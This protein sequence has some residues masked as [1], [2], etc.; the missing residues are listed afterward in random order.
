MQKWDYAVQ[1]FDTDDEPQVIADTLNTLGK[2]GWELV[3]AVQLVVPH[4]IALLKR[5]AE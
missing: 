3:A 1:R 4:A 5:P 2:E